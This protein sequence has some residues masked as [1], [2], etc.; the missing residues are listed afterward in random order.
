MASANDA[1]VASEVSQHHQS[2]LS[3]IMLPGQVEGEI[4][5]E[6]LDGTGSGIANT[7]DIKPAS[8]AQNGTGSTTSSG[9]PE[10]QPGFAPEQTSTGPDLISHNGLT[11]N[12]DSKI[13]TPDIQ[14]AQGVQLAAAPASQG[15]QFSSTGEETQTP[16]VDLNV[17][18]V[19]VVPIAN[20]S[21]D[22]DAGFSFTVPPASF[23][24]V[25]AGDTLTLSATL[26]DGSPLPSWL[27]FD[28]ATQTFSGTPLNDD[29]G[30]LS[31]RVTATDTAG[32]TAF[33]DF[34]I[35]VANTNDA[36]T[37]SVA[38][39]N[40]ST[41]EDAG[42]NFTVPATSFS[43]VDVGDSLTL[44]ATL[45]DGSSLPSWLS[46]DPATQTFTGTPLNEDVGALSVRVTAT[47]TA[48]ATAYQD[49]TVTIAN[50]NDA[51]VASVAIAD[52]STDEDAG[53]SFTVPPASF[54][55]VDVGDSLTYSATLADG[56]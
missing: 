15:E 5:A 8:S 39:A 13:L 4:A 1:Q 27:S 6:N 49:F 52:Q 7:S 24:D 32:A 56:S 21:T 16:E 28:P 10:D 14:L 42:F 43:D 35:T 36:P 25:D 41:D 30:A 29:V 20:Q 47:D 17:S 22:E 12:L 40:Q 51:P 34:T 55:D 26:A 33:Q 46:F 11:P 2:V 19:V 23:I 9:A 50:T 31:I 48:G 53:F 37:A 3:N 44:S 18:P 54:T 45:A 38:I